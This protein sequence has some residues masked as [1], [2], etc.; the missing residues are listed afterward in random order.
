[1]ALMDHRF[2]VTVGCRLDLADGMSLLVYP[3]DSAAYGRLC[4]LSSVGKQRGGKGK[5]Q[6]EWNDVAHYIDC[7]NW[8]S[9]ADGNRFRVA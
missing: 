8:S 9:G 7:R 3:T 5:G 6:L 2:E 4:R 1:M